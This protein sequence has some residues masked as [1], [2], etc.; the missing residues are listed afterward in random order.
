MPAINATAY[1]YNLENITS[2]NNIFEFVQEAN[3]LSGEIFMTGMLFA[4]F[5]VA[6]TAMKK[7]DN[8]KEALTVAS[9]MTMA[10]AIFFRMLEF[11]STAWTVT[12]ILL[13]GVV[14]AFTMFKKD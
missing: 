12:I 1:P 2:V 10:M 5:I 3:I 9:F 14:F 11:I 4:G 6:F 13:F 7:P 8:N